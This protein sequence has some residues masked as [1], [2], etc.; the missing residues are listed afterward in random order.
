MVRRPASLLAET[1]HS[2]NRQRWMGRRVSL[3]VDA[4]PSFGERGKCGRDKC[5]YVFESTLSVSVSKTE[6]Q[7][8]LHLTLFDEV[9]QCTSEDPNSSLSACRDGRSNGNV[10]V[11][12]CSVC[13]TGLPFC[14][15]EHA[16]IIAF[17]AVET[18]SGN[19]PKPSH[20]VGF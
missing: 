3:R 4:I 13:V 6:F 18:V 1:E 11:S 8:P 16:F 14:R 7:L 12:C 20:T 9:G 17:E 15:D 2:W 10:L 19:I 5:L